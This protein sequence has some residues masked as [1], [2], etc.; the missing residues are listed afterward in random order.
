[1]QLVDVALPVPLA[2]IFSYALP[3][4]RTTVP[5]GARV[6]C[7]FA[8]RRI[9]GVALG[10]REGEPPPGVKAVLDVLDDDDA[11]AVPDDLLTFLREVASYYLAPLGEVV[12]LA[13]PPVDRKT[14]EATRERTLF[15]DKK[16]LAP[17][18]VQWVRPL[19]TTGTDEP[20]LRGQAPQVLAHLRASG[21]APLA[22]LESQWK[23][24]RAVTKKLAE[25]GL[26]E[27]VTREAPRDP[28]FAEAAPHE[29]PPELT[30]A[31]VTATEAIEAALV[32]R[33]PATFLL[34]GVTGSGKTEVYLHAI[35][36]ARKAGRGTI[37]L[38]PEIAL[39]PQLVARFRG[40]FGDEVAV[41]HSALTPR[42][43]LDMWRM[44]RR[45][46]VD[47]AIGARSALF[48][49]IKDLGLVVVDEEH[50]GSF[51]QEEGVRY[52]AR[53]MAILRAHRA[54][55]VCVLGSATP[56]LET[57][58][59]ARTGR[60][61]RLVLPGRARAQAMP[62]VEIVDLRR[63]GPGPTG[64]KRLSLPLHRAIEK[65]LEQG[66]QIILFLNRRGFSHFFSCN[67]CGAELQC[68]HCSVGLTWHREQNQLVCHYCGYRRAA[69]E[70]CPECG[71]LD[72]GWAGFGT[73]RV[74][75]EAASLFPDLR[76]RRLDAD[77]TAR[78][79]ELE[80]AL[81][82]FRE[83]RADLLLGTQMVAKG[84]NF[85]R[86]RTVGV[87][88]ADTSLNLPDFRAA[89]RAFS[90]VVQVAGRAGRYTPD[91][92][93]IVQTFRPES[94]VIRR[95]AALDSESFYREE[96]A[97]RAELGFPPFTRLVRLV[98]RS[99][100]KN[101]AVLAARSFAE[102]AAT[103]IPA[104]AD[105]LGPAECPLG[106][107]AGTYRWQLLL[108]SAELGPLHR[109]VS[110]LLADYR[111]PAATRVEVDVDPVS[112]M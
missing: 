104:A 9:V 55:G 85:P 88:L 66:E 42:E 3:K 47:V 90:L 10:V 22:R 83:G 43:R 74:E 16:G 65:A 57:E 52:H 8:G 35:A 93:V 70:A 68:R 60:A 40:R 73:E 63:M 112:L 28:F 41:L 6:L 82:D 31:Q 14:L 30:D 5:P 26:V 51:K 53:D 101:R 75:E 20:S 19:S 99:K 106:L 38:V 86:V 102:L 87:V 79:G 11:P 44:L 84:L 4:E 100:E 94:P 37:V 50:D 71:S 62:K 33:A 89:E 21:E 27:V 110:T 105:L 76:L 77:S 78:S 80:S 39:T 72:V 98:F 64:D 107:V 15:D 54:G 34:Q 111:P 18:Q 23:N 92:R 108:R 29:P 103:A 59:L 58:H 45:G 91:G 17:R 49:P 61:T 1:M 48:A 12:R 56:S 46:E 2:R 96:L 7:P 81:A 67:T 69:P 24:A 32:K 13:L 109:A 97:T 25:L 95:A 36:A